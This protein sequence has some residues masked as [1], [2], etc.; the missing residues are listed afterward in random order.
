MVTIQQLQNLSASLRMVGIDASITDSY[1]I[2]QV[3]MLMHDND[4]N[5]DINTLRETIEQSNKDC[6][7]LL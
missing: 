1:I 4:Y 5:V 7:E 6:Q 3:C 2:Q